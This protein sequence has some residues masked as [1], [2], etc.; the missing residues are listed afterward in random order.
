MDYKALG[1]TIL[2]LL[3]IFIIIGVPVYFVPATILIPA[4]FFVV[5]IG[6]PIAFMIYEA[7]DT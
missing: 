4:I 1:K 6:I 2:L 7:F 3:T 5:F